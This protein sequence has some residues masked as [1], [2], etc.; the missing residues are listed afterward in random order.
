VARDEALAL[1]EEARTRHHDSAAHLFA[2]R[3]PNYPFCP[4]GEAVVTLSNAHKVLSVYC[5]SVLK[6]MISLERLCDIVKEET[7]HSPQKYRRTIRSIRYPTPE[8]EREVVKDEGDEDLMAIFL[9]CET[10]VARHPRYKNLNTLQ[11]DT[12]CFFYVAAVQLRKQGLIG[13]DNTPSAHARSLCA[14]K[15]GAMLSEST[16]NIKPKFR[17]VPSQ[18]VEEADLEQGRSRWAGTPGGKTGAGGGVCSDES[19]EEAENRLWST[20]TED[21][22]DDEAT[23]SFHLEHSCTVVSSPVFVSN[24]PSARDDGGAISVTLEY[25]GKVTQIQ[26]WS[27]WDV[28][29]RLL[30]STLNIDRAG[31]CM[32][33]GETFL[34]TGLRDATTAATGEP[35]ER[36]QEELRD[37]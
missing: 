29:A 1:S 20:L 10:E 25:L 12:R 21:E 11:K 28:L 3:N 34:L 37:Q 4:P 26:V 24:K 13:P 2:T 18:G 23:I 7:Q 5:S 8:G 19:D 16:L 17:G 31:E 36:C 15:C 14:P 32:C 6:Q 30:R 27:C 9:A 22:T 35:S 33:G